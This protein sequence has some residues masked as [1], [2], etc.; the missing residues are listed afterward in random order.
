MHSSTAKSLSRRPPLC[1]WS[2][3]DALIDVL[4]SVASLPQGA[5][6]AE[7]PLLRPVRSR[8]RPLNRALQG[9]SGKVRCIGGCLEQ[10]GMTG[11][12]QPEKVQ[13]LILSCFL[14]ARLLQ[15]PSLPIGSL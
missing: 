3:V 4:A 12:I 11:R 10:S 2:N 14:S 5:A 15:P 6:P 13:S 8:A 9:L 7:A 1:S